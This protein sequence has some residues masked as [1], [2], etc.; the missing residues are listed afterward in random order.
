MSLDRKA[1]GTTNPHVGKVTAKKRKRK[2][3][4]KAERKRRKLQ[5]QADEL[6]IKKDQSAHEKP[7]DSTGL[8]SEGEMNA[9]SKHLVKRSNNSLLRC[10]ATTAKEDHM[11]INARPFSLLLPCSTP[12]ENGQPFSKKTSDSTEMKDKGAMN[13][14]SND[15]G[16]DS[17]NSVKCESTG[18]KENDIAVTNRSLPLSPTCSTPKDL[19]GINNNFSTINEVKFVYPKN[20]GGHGPINEQSLNFIIRRKNNALI[21]YIYSKLQNT[22]GKEINNCNKKDIIEGKKSELFDDGEGIDDILYPERKEKK[23]R[24][25]RDE[26]THDDKNSK[27]MIHKDVVIIKAHDDLLPNDRALDVKQQVDKET[28]DEENTNLLLAEE[29]RKKESTTQDDIGNWVKEKKDKEKKDHAEK[30]QGEENKCQTYTVNQ[31][32]PDSKK[33]AKHMGQLSGLTVEDALKDKVGRRPR[34]NSTDRELNL[35][36]RGLCDEHTVLQSHKWNIEKV[37]GKSGCN[38]PPPRGFTNLGNTCFLN[39]TL[40][41]L[42]HLPTFGQFVATMP[43][44]NETYNALNQKRGT[45]K[46]MSNGQRFTMYLRTLVREMHG[47]NGGNQNRGPIAPR[48][49]V[50]SMPLLGGSSRG[51]QFRPGRQEDAHEFLVHLMDI[52]NDGELKAAGIDQK[53]SGWRDTIPIPRLDET[54]FVHRM[55]GG[56]LRSQVQCTKCRFS[57]NTYDPFLDLSLEISAKNANSISTAFTAFTRKETLD[58]ANKWKCSGCK[59]SVC[60]TKQLTCFRPPLSLCIQLKRFSFGGG[61]A[62]F[63]H[64]KGCWGLGH[65]SGKGMGMMRGGSKIQKPVEFPAL[66][67]LPL[68]D[69]RKC[70]YELTGIVI[71]VGGSATSGHYTAYVRRPRFQGKHSWYQCD[72]S[73]IQPVSERT[74]LRQKDAYILFYCRKEVKLELPPPPPRAIKNAGEARR[75]NEAIARARLKTKTE[76]ENSED[77]RPFNEDSYDNSSSG[78]HHN[79]SL[80]GTFRFNNQ[81]VE[82][83]ENNGMMEDSLEVA[84]VN[85]EVKLRIPDDGKNVKNNSNDEKLI[86]IEEKR[87]SKKKANEKKGGEIIDIGQRG[88][89]QG[90]H[91]NSRKKKK[92][93]PFS[94]M[95]KSNRLISNLDGKGW[96]DDACTLDDVT[97]TRQWKKAEKSALLRE[98]TLVDIIQKEKY[99]QRKMSPNKWDAELD[100]GKVKNVKTNSFTYLDKSFHGKENPFQQIQ[101]DVMQNRR[102]GMRRNLFKKKKNF[103]K[104]YFKQL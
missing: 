47:L 32:S 23:L 43:I 56:Y 2:R 29:A 93:K 50:R 89:L 38:Y 30:R 35:P 88:S 81:N 22:A 64:K 28:Q 85:K 94:P 9:S 101:Q 83:N 54:T 97:Y 87:I 12:K 57:S 71:H 82:L 48:Q 18:V 72:D 99:R 34:C 102:R 5:R 11:T 39:A 75:V 103:S 46:K 6:K 33:D 76:G 20:H 16:G 41:C 84:Q 66:L 65:F 61:F 37:C 55:F 13:A 52:M 7:F 63:V 86:D 91:H 67:K 59:K 104:R 17:N 62:G 10:V 100:K 96:D 95:F 44:A 73:F 53:K 79:S 4:S 31:S 3:V 60:A 40:Q 45:K 1:E 15:S 25:K 14:D 98:A 51:H 27:E 26:T 78:K 36:Q 68:S 77:D 69:G 21:P 24:E 74:V 19:F 90:N 70:D 49:I 58:A 8:K 42:G 80:K 92:W